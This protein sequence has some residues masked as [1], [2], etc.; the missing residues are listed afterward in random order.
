MPHT[1]TPDA[2]GWWLRDTGFSRRVSAADLRTFMQVCPER[3]YA[4]GETLFHVGDPATHLHVVAKGQVK[5]VVPTLDGR[6]RILA[7]VGPDDLFG[8]AFVGED[9]VYRLDAV[10]LTEVVTCPMDQEQY[11]RLALHAPG[12]VV[13]FTRILADKVFACRDQLARVE[14]PIRSRVAATLLEQ[15]TRYGEP[16]DGGWLE[17]TTEL[18]HEDL[19]AIVSA[20]RVSVTSAVASLRQAGVLEGTR[21]RY[22]LHPE[23]LAAAAAS[24]ES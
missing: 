15:A 1:T 2:T 24:Y 4:R 18:R 8:E 16:A 11:R 22:R 23:G 9:D 13:A 17:W 20:T 14:A 21:G 6:E 3:R 10:A 7:V 19:A 5:L 12:F